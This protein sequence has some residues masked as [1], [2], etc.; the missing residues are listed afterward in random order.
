MG[1][2]AYK[3]TALT[4]LSLPGFDA[5]ELERLT[6]GP[7]HYGFHATM[8]APFE[9]AATASKDDLLNFLDAFAK[10]RTSFHIQV[11][12]AA[13]GEFIALRL[14]EPSDDMTRLHS[15]CVTEFDRFRAP[16]SN[17][18]IARRRRARL[19]P[20]QDARMLKWGYPYI[21]DDFRWH[22]TL[23]NRIKSDVT[24]TKAVEGLQSLFAGVCAAPLLVDGIAIY[25]QSSRD[26]PFR[27]LKRAEFAG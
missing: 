14:S 13:L 25:V 3:C 6:N 2:D 27:V 17:S 16:L 21:F 7:R 18:D 10:T 26:A 1:R 22:M 9:L 4:P 19:T 24:R 15:A 5:E 8:K 20:E 11:A 23:S 12:P